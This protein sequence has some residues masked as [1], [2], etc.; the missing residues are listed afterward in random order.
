MDLY[1][2]VIIEIKA[3]SD[4]YTKPNIAVIIKKVNIK[5][6]FN[7]RNNHCFLYILNPLPISP[8]TGFINI[9]TIPT[10]LGPCP[11]VLSKLSYGIIKAIINSIIPNTTVTFGI[12]LAFT[13]SP[14][15]IYLIFYVLMPK[16]YKTIFIKGNMI[17]NTKNIFSSLEKLISL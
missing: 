11:T 3:N 8:K 14:R 16:T 7:N 9:L 17:L 10:G 5:I 12:I 2:F 13:L 6:I 15:F 4:I 1:E